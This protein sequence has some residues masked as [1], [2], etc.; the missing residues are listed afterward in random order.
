MGSGAR[1]IIAV[2]PATRAVSELAAFPALIDPQTYPELTVTGTG[3]IVTAA[4]SV[5]HTVP[6]P[7]NPE[8]QASPI[9]LETRTMTVLPELAALGRCTPNVMLAPSLAAAGGTDFVAS[10]G[11]ACWPSSVPSAP[12]RAAVRLRTAAGTLTIPAA[13]GPA[14]Q[15]FAP[16]ITDLRVTG[17][18]VA[19]VETALPALGSQLQRTLVVAGGAT[20]QVLLRVPFGRFPLMLGL[21][22]DGTVVLTRTV[23]D[24]PCAANIVSPAAPSLRRITLAPPFC[25]NWN[26]PV[27]VSGRRFVYATGG[28]YGV[29]DL[30]G[31]VHPLTEA[32]GANTGIGGSPVALDGQTAFV[33]RTDCDADRLLAVDASAPGS[34][35]AGPG[36]PREDA[37]SGT[38]RGPGPAEGRSARQRADRP[39][40]PE[41]LPRHVAARRAA[42]RSPRADR[43]QRALRE[44]RRRR[45]RAP[46]ARA[47]RAAPR[48]LRG[49]AA[50]R[51]GALRRGGVAPRPGRLPDRLARALPSRR[52][53]AVRRAACGATS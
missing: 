6:K 37:L 39:A 14:D 10:I 47:V 52:R 17:P 34:G 7:T 2:D 9:L 19:W 30:N 25:A 42:P 23:D 46:R 49:R 44:R 32:N 1:R 51:R 26:A 28:G 11:D 36:R 3:G 43:R 31:T 13:T 33:V 29:S 12:S 53:A 38:A 18:M 48:G 16:E 41:G 21:G 5:F 27:A 15:W 20:G 45:R 8:E 50:R 40:L 4:L 22:A 24:F 35:A